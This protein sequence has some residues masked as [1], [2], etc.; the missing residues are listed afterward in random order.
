MRLASRFDGKRGSMGSWMRAR[1]ALPGALLCAAWLAGCGGGDDGGDDGGDGGDGSGDV[2]YSRDLAPIFAEK[3]NFCHQNAIIQMDFTKPFDSEVGIVERENSWVVRGSEEEF[4][5]DPGNPDNSFIL[6]KVTADTLE[7]EVEGVPMPLVTP[8]LT[9]GE[10]DAV[11]TWIAGGAQDDA[12]F[13]ESVAPIFGT[14]VS[15][16]GSRGKCTFCHYP[17]SPPPRLDVTDPFGANGFVD[18]NA[19][20]GGVRVVPGDPDASV[21]MQKLLGDEEVGDPMP[22]VPER[23]TDAEVADLTAWIEAGAPNN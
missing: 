5:V 18:V 22:F 7:E 23:M 1:V 20:L 2:S 14:E 8:A 10:L 4:V 15:L 13:E 16:G 21:L 19:T 11:E 6:T 3:C 17:G 9:P 12:F